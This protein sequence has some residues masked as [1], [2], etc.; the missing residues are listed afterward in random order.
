MRS[1]CLPPTTSRVSRRAIELLAK[2]LAEHV[3][4]ERAQE[5]PA[6]P[7]EAEDGEQ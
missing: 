1:T 4:E 3:R 7:A 5:R 2:L 6:A